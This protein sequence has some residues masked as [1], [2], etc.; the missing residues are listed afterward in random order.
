MTILE[1]H[2]NLNV[3]K[4]NAMTHSLPTFDRELLGKFC[5]VTEKTERVKGRVSIAI[6]KVAPCCWF[7][8]FF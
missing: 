3:F 2:L 4:F 8:L 6:C 7:S 5:L 1:Q